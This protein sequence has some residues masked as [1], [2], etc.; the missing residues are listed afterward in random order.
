MALK[1]I[2]MGT[3][4][5][6]VPILIFDCIMTGPESN[7]GSIFIIEIPVSLSK[8]IIALW[9]GAAPLHFGKSEA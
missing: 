2:F 8:F 5:F 6:A 4:E 7:F 3:P 1:I 9:I